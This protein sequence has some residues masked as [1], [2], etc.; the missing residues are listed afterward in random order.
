MKPM[1]RSARSV[2]DSKPARTSIRLTDGGIDGVEDPHLVGDMIDVDNI[3]H[4]RVKALE[5]ASGHFGVECARAYLAVGEVVEQSAGDRRLADSALVRPYQYHCGFCH[6]ALRYLT[7]YDDEPSA[8]EQDKSWR[9]QSK[10]MTCD[11]NL[12]R[13]PRRTRSGGAGA[14]NKMDISLS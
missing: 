14:Q 8:A 11:C 4:A 1:S 6:D 10:N 12:P 7:P 2:G 3:R 9:D 13:L 5:R